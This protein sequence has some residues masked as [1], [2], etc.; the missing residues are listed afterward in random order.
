[1]S[2]SITTE[3]RRPLG[4]EEVDNLF[5][6]FAALAQAYDFTLLIVPVPSKEEAESSI[7]VLRE[8]ISADVPSELTVL[9]VNSAIDAWLEQTGRE[10]ES[11]YF[12]FDG[13]FNAEGYAL[14]GQVVTKAVRP[15]LPSK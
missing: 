7:N 4:S 11:L 5:L 8:Q 12:D 2:N 13:H 14:F 15:Y 1:M 6:D 3:P 10:R 9:D